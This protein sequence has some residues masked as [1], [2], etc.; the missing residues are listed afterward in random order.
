MDMAID[1]PWS[2]QKFIGIDDHIRIPSASAELDK[3]TILN[4]DR[5]FFG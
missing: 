4:I 2:H 3:A 5:I 1:Q